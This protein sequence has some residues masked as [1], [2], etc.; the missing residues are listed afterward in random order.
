[1]PVLNS[2]FVPWLSECEPPVVP[3]LHHSQEIIYIFDSKEHTDPRADT[4]TSRTETCSI[5][6]SLLCSL[7]VTFV[8]RLGLFLSSQHRLD[9]RTSF[10][11]SPVPAT[12]AVHQL[13]RAPR[14]SRSSMWSRRFRREAGRSGAEWLGQESARQ[15]WNCRERHRW[16]VT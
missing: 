6:P 2:V 3:A 7:V 9:W 1:M 11:A 8:T 4:V 5:H 15:G 14:S 12:G 16:L 13:R 10:F